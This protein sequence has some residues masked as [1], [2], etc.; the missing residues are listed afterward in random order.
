MSEWTFSNDKGASRYELRRG[1]ELVSVLEYRDN[2]RTV[3]LTRAVTVPAHRG[4]GY[5]AAITEHAVSEIEAAGDRSVLPVCWYVAEWFADHPE[6]AGVLA[7]AS[8]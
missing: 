7:G 8:R 5:A 3:A 6:R 2:G 4:K 1:G